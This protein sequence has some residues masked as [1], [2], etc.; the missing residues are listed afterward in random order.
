MSAKPGNLT[1]EKTSRKT[2]H[3]G[4]KRLSGLMSNVTAYR[5]WQSTHAELK[6]DPVRKH[7]DLKNVRRV[8]D[9][10]CGPGSNVH[11]FQHAHYLGV[12]LDAGC[13]EYA[14]KRYPDKRFVVADVRD[15][16]VA[17]G[18]YDFI[19]VNSVL[20]HLDRDDT[21]TL[22]SGLAKLLTPDGYV[23]VVEL[24]L[25]ER[26]GIAR[27]LARNDRGDFARPLEEWREIFLGSFE[28]AVF[29]PFTLSAAGIPL[30]QLVYFKGKS[31]LLVP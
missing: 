5:L 17:S 23:H 6:F 14:S 4:L 10:G 25:P 2:K 22:L 27:F 24:V 26:A 16:R 15:Y 11:H 7:T 9:V 12:D 3:R 21:R 20:H 31:R 29:E 28:A 18:M 30:L 13:I 1:G 19:L 8:L